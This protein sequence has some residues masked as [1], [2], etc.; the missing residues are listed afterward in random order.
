MYQHYTHCFPSCITTSGVYNGLHLRVDQAAPRSARLEAAT[1]RF[2]KR[3]ATAARET[4]GLPAA[5]DPARSVFVGNLHFETQDEELITLFNDA[6]D[7]G[8]M[9]GHVEAVRC[10]RDGVTNIGK[11]IAFVLFADKV[12]PGDCVAQHV[13]GGYAIILPST[14]G[15]AYSTGHVWQHG[16]WARHSRA[17]LQ[18]NG[19]NVGQRQRGQGPAANQGEKDG[20][21]G[22]QEARGQPGGGGANTACCSSGGRGVCAGKGCAMAGHEDQRRWQGG[23]GGGKAARGTA[24]GTA[25]GSSGGAGAGGA[26]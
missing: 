6:E 16:A 10:V 9:R 15:G 21:P 17:A 7:M 25:G 24:C 4:S 20:A 5:Y 26:S 2:D 22:R 3:A 11:G 19:G 18:V 1:N 13:D 8:D 23:K 14:G 12:M